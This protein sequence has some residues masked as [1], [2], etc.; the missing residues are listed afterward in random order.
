MESS[1]W[2]ESSAWLGSAWTTAGR[3]ASGACRL[4]MASPE[5]T[6]AEFERTG[7]SLLVTPADYLEPTPDDHACRENLMP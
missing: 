6:T 5:R 2:T 3:L 1:P 4:R 7:L